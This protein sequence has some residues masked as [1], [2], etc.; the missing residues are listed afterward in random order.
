MGDLFINKTQPVGYSNTS[1]EVSFAQRQNQSST[2]GLEKKNE[3]VE[4]A[5]KLGIT[6]CQLR[7]IMKEDPKFLNLSFEQQRETVT[8]LIDENSVEQPVEQS[9]QQ[10]IIIESTKS[11]DVKAV[12]YNFSDFQKADLD[13]KVET[14]AEELAKNKFLYNSGEKQIAEWEAL[15]DAEKK[16]KIDA[17]RNELNALK[18]NYTTEGKK[19]FNFNVYLSRKM[20][21]LQAANYHEMSLEKFEG[22]PTKDQ[23]LHDYVFAVVDANLDSKSG[24]LKPEATCTKRQ[25]EYYNRQKFLTKAIV[26]ELRRSGD[27]SLYDSGADFVMSQSEIKEHCKKL[28]KLPFEIEYNYLKHKAQDGIKLSDYEKSK[29]DDLKKFDTPAGKQIFASLKNPQNHGIIE[30]LKNSKYGE[31]WD[32][33]KNASDEDKMLILHKYVAEKMK[34]LPEDEKSKFFNEFISEYA[35][36]DSLVAI[37][38]AT[39]HLNR[40]DKKEQKQLVQNATE[41]VDLFLAIDVNNLTPEMKKQIAEKQNALRKENPELYSL[42]AQTVTQ[43]ADEGSFES[44]REGYLKSNDKK[45]LTSLVYRAYDAKRSSQVGQQKILLGVFENENI[46]VDIRKQAAIR[47]DEAYKENQVSLTKIASKQKEVN[48]AMIEDGTFSRFEK[49]NQTQAF[50]IL[51]KRTEQSDYTDEEAIEQLNKLSDGIQYCDKDNQLDM[52]NSM[53]K[54]KYSEVQEHTAGNIKNYDPSVQ[55]AAMDAVYA[56]GNE[57]AIETA[58]SGLSEFKSSDVQRQETVRVIC[59]DALNNKKAD[60]KEKF[61]SGEL[62]YAEVK[63][64][65]ASQRRYYFQD[66]FKKLPLDKK[67]KILSNMSCGNAQKRII[68]TMIARNNTHLFNEICKDKD[69]V[70]S[71]LEMGLP[72]DVKNKVK[73]VVSFLAVADI[74]FQGIAKKYDIEYDGMKDDYPP[75]ANSLKYSSVPDNFDN[76]GNEK[77]KLF[78]KDQ[79]GRLLA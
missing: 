13:S 15:S 8:Q 58:V 9:V 74:G 41:L 39:K 51:K 16:A 60:M 63:K 14:Y 48:D 1:G 38:F 77:F 12:E 75:T 64:L 29:Y 59:E 73:G 65:P 22:E 66:Y 28:N 4:L 43:I 67:I 55:S 50:E 72:E 70:A 26:D 40:I 61:L 56:S 71:L 23:L 79:N 47:L 32:M 52:H 57:K 76:F 53:M 35:A 36:E 49:E 11:A 10:N 30:D 68:F 54:S 19:N 21:I 24:N 46:D 44:F 2:I 42:L 37:E 33:A 17:E 7:D 69:R 45:V 25:F 5:E 3:I 18:K 78:A 20:E 6:S 31:D 27:T 34:S 62:T